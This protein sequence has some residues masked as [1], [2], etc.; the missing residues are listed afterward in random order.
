MVHTE[1]IR[2]VPGG[3]NAVLMIHGILGTPRH[4]D[5]LLPLIPEDWAV[6]NILLDGHGGKVTDFS[7]SS[8]KK[9]K[10]QVSERL[11][12]LLTRYDRV[13]LVAHSMG[14]LFSIQ[15][16]IRR[17]DKIVGLFLLQTPLRPRLKLSSAI[18]AALMPFGIVVKA[19]ED[20]YRG[21]SV[22]MDIRVW[23]YLG[24][25]PRFLELFRECAATRKLLGQICVPCRIY[26]SAKD[27]MVSTRSCRDLAPHPRLQVT[28]LENSGHFA[29]KGADLE[30]V[31]KDFS[32]LFA[33]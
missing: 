31:M 22:R 27:E 16:S 29:Y 25:I 18:H 33:P 10:A 32:L 12:D 21:T 30:R 20:M 17:P 3:R 15:E 26:Q 11:D 4:F 23:R 28:V 6:A 19:A 13:L 7:H 5:F 1:Y 24:W 8:M 2:E 9:W 14:T